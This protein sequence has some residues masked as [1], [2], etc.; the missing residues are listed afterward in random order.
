MQ[1]S[2]NEIAVLVPG[3]KLSLRAANKSQNTIVAY[4]YAT[5]QLEAFLRDTGMPLEVDKI[6]REHIEAF[7]VHVRELTSASTAETRYRGLRQFFKWCEEEGEIDHS[8]MQNM[9]PPKVGVTEKRVPQTATLD[10]ILKP[11]RKAK[12][13]EWIDRRDAAIIALF[14][15]SGLRL[16]ELTNLTV[17]DI[18]LERDKGGLAKVTGKGDKF[19]VVSFR[20]DVA[21]DMGRWLVARAR[22]L[23]SRGKDPETFKPLW[24][25][26]KGNALTTSGIRQMVWSRSEAV[27]ERIHPHQLRHLF[28]SEWLRA[29]KSESGLM[30]I[31][32]WASRQMIDN[33]YARGNRSERA[34]EEHLRD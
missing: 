12:V 21:N 9:K 13:T 7:L 30:E 3:W 11:L 17:D 28:A 4:T 5:T 29:G 10:S 23:A 15:G 25:G 6:T 16:S 20:A 14:A 8:P 31:G 27:G 18:D 24:I 34:I 32:G 33:V 2:V 1:G 19:R 22:Y 26:L